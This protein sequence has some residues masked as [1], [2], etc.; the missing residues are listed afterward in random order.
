MKNLTIAFISAMITCPMLGQEDINLENYIE[1]PQSFKILKTNGEVT[2]FGQ[3]YNDKKK[4][5]GTEFLSDGTTRTGYYENDQFLGDFIVSPPWHLLDLDF[6]LRRDMAFETFSI[7]L[8]VNREIDDSAFFY[9]APLCGEINGIGFYGGIQ[10]QG[11]GYTS[12][13]HNTDGS[14]FSSLGRI[15]IFSRWGIRD[16]KAIKMAE[17]G[18]CESSG[19]EGDFVSVRNT[20]NWNKGSYTLSIIN[21]HKTVIIDDVLHSY[22]EMKVLDHYSKEE[23]SLGKLAFPGE[24]MVLSKR[25][26]AFIEHYSTFEKLSSIPKGSIS[27]SKIKINKNLQNIDSI[28]NYSPKN[29][30]QW[31][32]S[33]FKDNTM[34]I[35]FGEPY[36]REN[37][38]ETNTIY[39]NRIK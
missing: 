32:R 27:L 15:G 33:W 12:A 5:I 13:K 14:A 7:D 26:Y 29:A 17:N 18:R 35:Q 25:N 28:Y 20:V 38:G 36:V 30:P 22:I 9:I 4:G 2:Y 34:E 3:V 1:Q 39:Y 6:D 37:Y 21:T 23:T 24:E 11:G 19:Y 10:T 8:T 31:A 16:S